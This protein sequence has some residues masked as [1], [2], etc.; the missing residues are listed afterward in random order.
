MQIKEHKRKHKC[1]IYFGVEHLRRV[2]LG[3]VVYLGVALYL[4]GN[5]PL[6]FFGVCNRDSNDARL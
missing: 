4:F 5:M 1:E 6:T 2:D 3:H